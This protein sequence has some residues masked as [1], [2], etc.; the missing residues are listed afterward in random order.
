MISG[1][2]S[3]VEGVATGEYQAVAGGRAT[4]TI[5]NTLQSTTGLTVSQSH[6]CQQIFRNASSRL[7]VT[8]QLSSPRLIARP[9]HTSLPGTS[10]PSPQLRMFS[11]STTENASQICSLQQANLTGRMIIS[12]SRFNSWE[13]KYCCNK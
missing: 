11:Q 2:E 12:L 7:E 3:K 1:R 8:I 10:S 4:S 5:T 6:Q 13:Y 9:S